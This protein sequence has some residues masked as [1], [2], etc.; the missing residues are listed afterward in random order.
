MVMG[1]NDP[2][3]AQPGGVGDDRANRHIGGRFVP[4]IPL[5]VNA[6]RRFVEMG[7]PQPFLRAI[8]RTEA[9][10]KEA[11]GGVEAVEKCR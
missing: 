10:G 4:L 8:L 2:G 9:G 1:E 5:Q 6:P 11:V 3:G 7:H